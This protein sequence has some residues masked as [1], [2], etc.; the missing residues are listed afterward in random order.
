M[1]FFIPLILLIHGCG[2]STKIRREARD[3]CLA[4]MS[5]PPAISIDTF[6]QA[7]N[8]L[9]SR[10]REKVIIPLMLGG[11]IPSFNFKFRPVRFSYADSNGHQYKATVFVSPDYLCLGDDQHFMRM[12]LTPQAAQEIAD[13][14]HCILPTRKLV[15]EIYL[16]AAIKLPPH[17]LTEKRD[18]L[19]TFLQHDSI[20]SSQLYRGH[21]HK[22]VAGIKKDVVQSNAVRASS[23]T[24]R[25]AIYGWHLPGGK[26]IQPLYTGHVDWYVDYSHGIRLVYEK[27]ILNGKIVFVKDVLNNPALQKILCDEVVCG[28][29]RY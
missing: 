23:K 20:I 11:Y 13:S 28:Y 3:L 8:P 21:E 4:K 16:H 7:L 19:V 25:V 18:S 29:M 17:T 24:N 14:F 1:R 5:H 27:M 22:L 2:I 12:P 6:V 26:P 15:D 9:S 10:D